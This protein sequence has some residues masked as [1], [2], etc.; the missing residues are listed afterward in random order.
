[1]G[2]CS[3]YRSVVVVLKRL[4]GEEIGNNIIYKRT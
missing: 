2:N 4:T 3:P 1:M